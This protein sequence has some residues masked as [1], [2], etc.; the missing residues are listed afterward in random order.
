MDRESGRERG[1]ERESVIGQDKG[2]RIGS[3]NR[4]NRK[5]YFNVSCA[6]KQ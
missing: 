6:G 5:I 1:I 2:Y 4:D 3:R